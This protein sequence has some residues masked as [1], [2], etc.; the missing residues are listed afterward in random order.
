MNT[1]DGSGLARVADRSWRRVPGRVQ[2][3]V[4]RARRFSNLCD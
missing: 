4:A 3:I 2:L 1:P